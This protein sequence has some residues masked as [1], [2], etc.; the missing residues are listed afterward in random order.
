MTE[1]PCNNGAELAR[2][3]ASWL[4]LTLHAAV[5]A[6][7]H[8]VIAVSGGM[9][10]VPLFHALR[11]QPLDWSR[12]TITLVDERC[13]PHDHLDSNT[14]LVR[15]HLLQGAAAAAHFVPFFDQLPAPLDDRALDALADI[16]NERLAAQPWPLDLAVLGMGED[17]HTASLFPGAPGLPRA[18]NGSGPVTWLRPSPASNAPHARLTL[19][20][21]ALLATRELALA[22]SG[23]SKLAVFQQARLGADEAL[24]VSLILNQHQTPVSVWLA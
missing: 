18:L 22:I 20:L 19:T 14:A 5:Q 21:P 23:A 1:H 24:P 15:T 16:A 13:V 3:L 11:Q 9:S 10:P 17:G 6:R 4:G 12:V 8:A 7:G 2:R